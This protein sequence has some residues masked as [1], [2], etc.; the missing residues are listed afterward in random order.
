VRERAN[1]S[2]GVLRPGGRLLLVDWRDDY[3]T[4][5]ACCL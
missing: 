2:G 3:L 4:W 1:S 5:N